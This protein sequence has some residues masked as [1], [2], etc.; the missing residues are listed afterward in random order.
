MVE[1]L[2]N[3]NLGSLRNEKSLDDLIKEARRV[4]FVQGEVSG[5]KKELER[6]LKVS[7]GT[8]FFFDFRKEVEGR[9][10]ELK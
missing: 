7:K 1:M 5:A 2:R 3:V 8:G 10:K 6:L 9:L 4:G